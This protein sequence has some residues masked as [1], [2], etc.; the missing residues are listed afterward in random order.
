MR[1]LLGRGV[2]GVSGGRA[3]EEEARGTGGDVVLHSLQSH[4]I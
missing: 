4:H 2:E 3:V 1:R